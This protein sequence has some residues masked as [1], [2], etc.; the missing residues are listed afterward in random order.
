M[1]DRLL[2]AAL[3]YSR[4]LGWHVFPCRGKVPATP[5]GVKDATRDEAKIREW[6]GGGA[7][8]AIGVACGESSGVLVVD[9]DGEE[10]KRSWARLLE[11]ADVL[12]PLGPVAITPGG[13]EHW[14]FAWSPASE[15]RNSVKK[16]PGLDVRS[17]GG[18]VLVNPSPHPNGGTY[19]WA[20]PPWKSALP[21]LPAWL[22][23]A[24]AHAPRSTKAQVPHD[25]ETPENAERY[26]RYAD[27]A[28][29]HACDRMKNA[30]PGRRRPL[31]NA[32]VFRLLQ[33]AYAG[34]GDAQTIK[35]SLALAALSAG[36]ADAEVQRI[37]AGAD[38]AASHR[39]E[40]PTLT[41]DE[42]D[43][44]VGRREEAPGEPLGGFARGG[45]DGPEQGVAQ[46]R[47]ADGVDSASGHSGDGRPGVAGDCPAGPGT[48]G[49]AEPPLDGYEP[50]GGDRGCGG[51]PQGGDG[52]GETVSGRLGAGPNE[53]QLGGDK[54]S[55]DDEAMREMG[56][57]HGQD[58]SKGVRD[59]GPSGDGSVGA[60]GGG[61]GGGGEGGA[62]PLRSKKAQSG[63]QEGGGPG[64]ADRKRLLS[65]VQDLS[66]TGLA[67]AIAS[68]ASGRLAYVPATKAWL[69]YSAETG[70]WEAEP[71]PGRA[72]WREVR[73]ATEELVP[74]AIASGKEATKRILALRGTRTIHD[75][76]RAMTFEPGLV[77]S[78]ADFDRHEHLLPT[79][80]GI[81][82]LRTGALVEPSAALLLSRGST[83]AYKPGAAAPTWRAFLEQVT[84]G[85]KE[86]EAFLQ[87][88]AGY[89]LTGSVKEQVF[90]FL[91][92]QGGNGK[93]TFAR[94]LQKIMGPRFFEKLPESAITVKRG[95]QQDRERLAADLP[96]CR[97][98]LADETQHGVLNVAFIKEL[99]GG[100]TMRSRRL[101]QERDLFFPTAKLWIVGNQLPLPPDVDAA[102]RRRCRRVRFYYD[103]T[104]APDGDL[105]QK[106]EAELE[107]ILAW[108]VEGAR[109]WYLG[110]LRPPRAVGDAT[111]EYLDAGDWF[112]EFAD[113]CLEFGD[114]GYEAPV[115]EIWAT[116]VA[117]CEREKRR[118]DVARA[119][120]L[121]NQL[122]PR[123]VGRR[124]GAQGKRLMVGVRVRPGL[125]WTPV[126]D[127]TLP[128]ADRDGI[129]F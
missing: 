38:L 127:V 86:L 44:H 48:A 39:P 22:E 26:A 33:F 116:Y 36:V 97:F 80:S 10:G 31:L 2:K 21:N 109:A 60:G 73:A 117:W 67:K 81:V 24:F 45:G 93:G 50:G 63:A 124:K 98:V 101:Y 23:D 89:T 56:L 66:D 72:P 43:V 75:V 106:L 51:H 58:E 104:Q 92:G 125:I 25:V 76:I 103:A 91:H 74:A 96:G 3:Y 55:G 71:V 100:D 69:S 46:D 47:G 27:R 42:G 88:A 61:A 37:I 111:D 118:L 16:L 107:G 64:G 19:Q 20:K 30:G 53:A 32:E 7:S 70:L 94:A 95:N 35:D 40:L 115:G 12:G 15:I 83:T 68:Q 8:F 84:Q 108:A 121:M 102:I 4:E 105:E 5:N 123:G 79:P 122:L 17:A 62:R 87:R 65:T 28:L 78:P 119:G 11:K 77:R 126:N 110:G 49:N 114:P 18:Y 9:V 129:P 113:S 52:G 90:F 82:D 54:K 57:L 41:D 1:S 128:P 59:A 29:A 14:F 112:G 6:W 85:D 34:M 13:G 99:T 120:A